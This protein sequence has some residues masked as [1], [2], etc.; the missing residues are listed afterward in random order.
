MCSCAGEGECTA[1]GKAAEK[2]K[3]VVERIQ[4]QVLCAIAAA[5]GYSQ[6][7]L[8]LTFETTKELGD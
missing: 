5:S 1:V 8:K 7:E 6:I 4:W 2:E 3:R